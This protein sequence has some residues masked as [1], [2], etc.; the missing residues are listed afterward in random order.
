[1]DYLLELHSEI[2]TLKLRVAKLEFQLK[3]E[4]QKNEILQLKADGEKRLKEITEEGFYKLAKQKDKL[5]AQL[6]DLK[7]SLCHSDSE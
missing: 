6:R 3:N 7:E 5:E 4:Q 1:M 2:I